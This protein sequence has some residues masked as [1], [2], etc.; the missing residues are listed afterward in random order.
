MIHRRQTW[1]KE[2]PDSFLMLPSRLA[3]NLLGN[4]YDSL[5]PDHAAPGENKA[6]N[7]KKEK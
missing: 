5:F 1:L 2:I 6:Q 3:P 4:S 7:Q